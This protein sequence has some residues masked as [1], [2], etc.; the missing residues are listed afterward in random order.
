MPNSSLPLN[1]D[2][3][4]KLIRDGSRLVDATRPLWQEAGRLASRIPASRYLP[5]A[6]GVAAGAIV[7]VVFA[8]NRPKPPAGP[9]RI[10]REREEDVD[11]VRAP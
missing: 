4:E 3:I 5:F 10:V 11:V 1:I 7:G 6:A 8:S 2:A 9:R